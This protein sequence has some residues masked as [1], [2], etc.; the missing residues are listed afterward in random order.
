MALH[1]VSPWN[2]LSI[3]SVGKQDEKPAQ[4]TAAPTVTGEHV[5]ANLSGKLFGCP[6]PCS[7]QHGV[8]Q[9]ERVPQTRLLR[10]PRSWVRLG[11]PRPHRSSPNQQLLGKLNCRGCRSDPAGANPTH[12]W[13][14]ET[15][16]LLFWMD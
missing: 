16:K 1:A 12:F 3:A 2:G 10:I 6:K 13:E 14:R 8:G 4:G 15:K 7:W 11:S 5:S 9:A